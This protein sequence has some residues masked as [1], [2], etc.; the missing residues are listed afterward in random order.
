[1]ISKSG[2]GILWPLPQLKKTRSEMNNGQPPLNEV[3]WSVSSFWNQIFI[4]TLNGRYFFQSCFATLYNWAPHLSK[5]GLHIYLIKA[6]CGNAAAEQL[7]GLEILFYTISEQT[8][9]S[10]CDCTIK[11]LVICRPIL[12]C[13]GWSLRILAR[14]GTKFKIPWNTDP[15]HVSLNNSRGAD[16]LV[17]ELFRETCKG[18]LFLLPTT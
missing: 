9:Q 4:L 14:Y 1:M 11:A 5:T 17:T 12:A 3:C 18:G 16:H 6:G 7:L 13:H 15:L 2:S 10:S 8:L